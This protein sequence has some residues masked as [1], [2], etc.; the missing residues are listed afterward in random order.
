MMEERG[1]WHITDKDGN[2]IAMTTYR[3]FAHL[4]CEALDLFDKQKNVN[5]VKN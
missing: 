2:I 1:V 3:K 5:V 4:L